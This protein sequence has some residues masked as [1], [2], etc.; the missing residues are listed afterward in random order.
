MKQQ[1]VTTVERERERESYNLLNVENMSKA[2][3]LFKTNYT[4]IFNI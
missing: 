4:K 2:V 1:N 3:Q